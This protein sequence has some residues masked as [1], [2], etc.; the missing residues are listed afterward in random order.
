M[1]EILHA[2]R[3]AAKLF[4][5][6][7]LLGHFQTLLKVNIPE[8]RL[9]VT[10]AGF[11]VKDLTV[12]VFHLWMEWSETMSGEIGFNTHNITIKQWPLS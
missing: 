6:L 2:V 11:Q 5:A 12:F 3:Q 7:A 4:P 10:D 1:G 8:S 9:Q